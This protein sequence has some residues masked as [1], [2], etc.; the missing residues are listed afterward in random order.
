MTITAAATH[1]T[2]ARASQRAHSTSSQT[3][4]VRFFSYRSSLP[5]SSRISSPGRPCTARTPSQEAA[6]RA[7]NPAI[8]R[9]VTHQRGVSASL[10]RSSWPF[11]TNTAASRPVSE[12]RKLRYPSA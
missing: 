11:S 2:P 9:P 8:S 1:R 4:F 12:T 5:A 10:L 3:V 7:R 6:I